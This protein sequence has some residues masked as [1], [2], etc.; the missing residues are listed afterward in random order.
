MK[1]EE[2]ERSLRLEEFRVVVKR[3]ETHEADYHKM[4]LFAAAG[5]A[6]VLGLAG[7]IPDFVIPIALG[8]L[9]VITSELAATYRIHQ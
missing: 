1:Q 5:F 8:M 7:K 4:L 2:A 6:A 3:L 9:L